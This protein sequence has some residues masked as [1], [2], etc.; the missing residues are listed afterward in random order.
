MAFMWNSAQL[1]APYKEGAV[2]AVG[3]QLSPAGLPSAWEGFV[4][5]HGQQEGLSGSLTMACSFWGG[6]KLGW[7]GC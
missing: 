6:S 7:V 1:Q 2:C 4:A 3:L 5:E